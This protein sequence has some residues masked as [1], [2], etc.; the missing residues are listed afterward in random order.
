MN[1]STAIYE[2]EK[3]WKKS[4]SQVDLF[5]QALKNKIV[6]LK[7]IR[8]H[9]KENKP[10]NMTEEYDL[11]SNENVPHNSSSELFFFNNSPLS[12]NENS[13]PTKRPNAMEPPHLAHRHGSSTIADDQSI[14]E[15]NTNYPMTLSSTSVAPSLKS[16]LVNKTNSVTPGGMTVEDENSNKHHQSHRGNVHNRNKSTTTKLPKQVTLTTIRT[17]HIK[18]KTTELTT[19]STISQRSIQA[20][21]SVDDVSASSTN[22]S[23]VSTHSSDSEADHKMGP[24][25]KPNIEN[26]STTVDTPITECFCEPD[27]HDE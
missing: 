20:I 27:T 6:E 11:D 23:P 26:T 9:L 14:D 19:E 17:S 8:R 15:S 16:V 24:L 4:R 2:D 3:R 7:D 12:F 13:R 18:S 1:C 25:R 21:K 22:T 10:K 5:I